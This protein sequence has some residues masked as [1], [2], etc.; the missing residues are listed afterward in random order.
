MRNV[1][2]FPLTIVFIL[3]FLFLLL[4]LFL[5]AQIGLIRAGGSRDYPPGSPAGLS[6]AGAHG[7][8]L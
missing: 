7:L 3:G 6:V 1:Y 5:F 8:C 2:F 4:L